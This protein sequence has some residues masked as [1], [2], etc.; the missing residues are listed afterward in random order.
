[1]NTLLVVE[2][3]VLLL[4]PS[5]AR[6]TLGPLSFELAS[7]EFVGLVGASGTGK[8][9]LL[10]TLAGLVPRAI[11]RG[12][13]SVTRPV[14]MAF[15]QDALDDGLTAFENVL[16]AAQGANVR[17]ARQ[18]SRA[19]LT[20]LG[21][22]DDLIARTPRTLSGGQRKR[23]GLARALVIRPRVLLL[24]D[25]TAGLDPDTAREVMDII[26]AEAADAAILFATQEVDA[27]LP[28]AARA[29]FL[30]RHKETVQGALVAPSSLPSP[31]APRA[32]RPL[33][34]GVVHPGKSP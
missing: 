18:V 28:R 30:S 7:G 5:P 16:V 9:L 22:D 14:S 23:V 31:Y 3:M 33:F 34:P 11:L 13:A 32:W 20:R 8:T 26:A 27:V 25:P 10:A 24:D 21:L 17:E 19:M 1:M 4:S 29:L 15:A 6:R 2:E 12:R